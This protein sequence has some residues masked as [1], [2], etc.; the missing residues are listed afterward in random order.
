MTW[1][2]KSLQT[3]CVEHYTT[4]THNYKHYTLHN[5]TTC[6]QHFLCWK[7]MEL[8]LGLRCLAI[9]IAHLTFGHRM[10]VSAIDH[11][12]VLQYLLLVITSY[13][14]HKWGTVILALDSP[15]GCIYFWHDFWKEREIFW[16]HEF[17]SEYFTSTK[18]LLFLCTLE[19]V[20]IFLRKILINNLKKNYTWLKS[21]ILMLQIISSK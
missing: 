14:D 19:K 12:F 20:F 11:N 15:D 6:L 10:G 1:D 3:F 7:N 9:V 2:E 21:K 16:K 4:T 5:Y 13:V 8:R 18:Y 17:F